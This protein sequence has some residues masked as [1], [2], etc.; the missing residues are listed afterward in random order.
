MALPSKRKIAAICGDGHIRAIEQDLPDLIL[1]QGMHEW[2]LRGIFYHG[3]LPRPQGTENFR[4]VI[5]RD[6]Y[7]FEIRVFMRDGNR[8]G[9]FFK[10]QQDQAAMGHA[11]DIRELAYHCVK[12][13]PGAGC[14]GKCLDD[15]NKEDEILFPKAV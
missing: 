2:I 4:V 7:A 1:F 10:I 8:P 11:Q 13:P 9:L 6:L 5:Q 12:G 15:F 3:N 14:C